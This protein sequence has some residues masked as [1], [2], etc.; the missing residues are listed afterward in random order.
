MKILQVIYSL[1]S[2]GAERF[3]T[4]LANELV[5]NEDCDITLLILKSDKKLQNLFYRKELSDKIKFYSLGVEHID[6]S[7]F[8]KLYK[9]IKS[10]HPD[11]VHINLSPIILFCSLAILML[12]K[13][14][15]V[16]TLHNEV[17]KINDSNRIYHILKKCIYRLKNVRVCTISDKNEREFQRV[18]GLKCDAL[19]Y[20]GRKKIVPTAD[21]DCVKNEIE[22]YKWNKET[23]VITHIARCAPQKNQDLLIDSFNELLKNKQ[24]VILLIIGN[25]FDSPRGELLRKKAQRGIFFLGEKHNVQD[26]LKCSDAFCLSSL[27]EGM[28]ITLIEALEYGCVPLSTPVSGITDLIVDGKNG[29]VSKDFTFESYVDMLNNYLGNRHSINRRSLTEL[30][31]QKLSISACAESYYNLYKSCLHA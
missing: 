30:Y 17:A 21:C 24:N 26:Y 20:N 3:I 15:F 4:D 22:S 7:I 16:E 27:Y 14:V 29:F 1:S 9:Y 12:R 23:L 2:G 28:P 18:Y 6:L 10:V 31:E 19:I 13:T 8:Y 11:I 5:K 25:G